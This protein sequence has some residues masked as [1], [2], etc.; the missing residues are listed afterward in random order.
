MPTAKIIN[1]SASIL[2]CLAVFMY[3]CIVYP[4]HISYQEHYQM[5]LY[6]FSYMKETVS[7]PGGVAGY[8]SAFLTQF[9][10]FPPAGALIVA[11]LLGA[12]QGLVWNTAKKLGASGLY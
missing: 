7:Y 8:L 1:S 4:F 11:L 9:F 5:F 6:N 12:L 3:F 10:L 2:F